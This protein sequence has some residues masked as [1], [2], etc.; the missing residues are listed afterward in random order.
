MLACSLTYFP[1]PASPIFWSS[2]FLL[3]LLKFFTSPVFIFKHS[4]QITLVLLHLMLC[5]LDLL[6]KYPLSPKSPGFSKVKFTLS[7]LLITYL[8]SHTSHVL[9]T[10]Y[11]MVLRHLGLLISWHICILAS[12]HLGI[13]AYW[14]LFILA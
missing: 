1:F 7:A 10:N 11:F 12:W 5:I 6:L 3:T 2:Y 9:V 4:C 14:H 8:Y 13:W